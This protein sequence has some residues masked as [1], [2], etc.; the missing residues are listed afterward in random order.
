MRDGAWAVGMGSRSSSASRYVLRS[1]DHDVWLTVGPAPSQGL[2]T[3]ST[4]DVLPPRP[5]LR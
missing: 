4:H 1:S 3:R 5:D 2:R